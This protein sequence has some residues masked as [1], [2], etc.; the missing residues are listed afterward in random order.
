MDLST[1]TWAIGLVLGVL[2]DVF[3]K[4][5]SLLGAALPTITILIFLTIIT[6]LIIRPLVGFSISA[7]FG[8]AFKRSQESAKTG[9]W[10]AIREKARQDVDREGYK[11]F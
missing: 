1:W 6:R 4:A 10:A 3:G 8:D 2:S 7:A 9:S 5:L 11:Y